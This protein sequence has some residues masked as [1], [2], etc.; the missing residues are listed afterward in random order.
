LIPGRWGALSEALGF[1]ILVLSASAEDVW[2]VELV[3]EHPHIAELTPSSA[4]VIN[5]DNGFVIIP[6]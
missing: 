1:G 4:I 6:P 2:E 3:P 5:T